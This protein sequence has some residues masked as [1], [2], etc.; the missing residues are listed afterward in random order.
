MIASF[1][2]GSNPLCGEVHVPGDKSLSHRAV[3]FSA[4]A[5][6]VTRVAGVL[7]SADVRSTIRAVTSLGAHVMLESQPDGSLAGTIEG[8]GERGPQAD[9]G[10]TI[11]CGNSG[12]TARLLMG[13]LAGWPMTVTLTGDES[14]SKRPMRRVIRPLEQ[15][16]ATFEMNC[17]ACGVNWTLPLAIRGSDAL[18]PIAY[19]SPVASAQVKSAILLAGL[20]AHGRTKVVEPKQSRD[21]TELLLPVFGVDVEVE[22]DTCSAAV[23]GPATLHSA[24]EI[25]VPR[26]P[27][28]AAFL[29]V[30]ALVVAGSH[31]TL[32]GVSLNETR[33]GFLRV[34]DRMGARIEVVPWPQTGAERVGEIVVRHTPVLAA[35]TVCAGEVPFLIDEVPIL[36]LVATQAHGETRFEGVGEL[37]VKES[38][39]LAAIVDG[40]TA[41]GAVASAEDDTLIVVGPSRL[42]SASLDSLGDHR[43][44][45]TWAVAGFVADGAV[46]VQDF[47]A[48]S[49]S[50]PDFARDIALLQAEA[51][52]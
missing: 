34:L 26:D 9:S 45:M 25:V 31:V 19:E 50:Y 14:L 5:E 29:T 4:M 41:L 51:G 12:T 32:P 17:A 21:H 33:T 35:T 10:L 7:N 11:D 6:G 42:R 43:L 24:G 23:E 27:S 2:P 3:L 40:L 30:A 20:R 52:T 46:T 49:V 47:D 44:A 37:R 1:G 8:W 16:G 15:M 36:A 22:R 13:V 18:E 28:S 38:D 48:V 39:R